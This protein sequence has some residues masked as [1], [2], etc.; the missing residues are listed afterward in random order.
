MSA[1]GGVSLT[2]DRLVLR[3]FAVTDEEAVHS[4]ASDP[5]VTQYTD[6]GPNSIDNTRAFLAEAT[7]QATDPERADFSL[8]VVLATSGELIGS[9]A[10]AV[11]SV[12]HKRG[13][14]GFVFHRDFWS[15][16]YATEAG[17]LLVHFGF[18]RLQLRRISATCHPNNSASARVLQ[19]VGLR[20]EGH[21]RSHLFV[22]G[23]W[24]SVGNRHFILLD[25][26]VIPADL[27][28]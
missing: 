4:F 7:G 17:K 2:S 15:Q 1:T 18:Q 9:A 23:S 19:K 11:T 22:R 25:N 13:E 6:W 10:I 8:A 12:Q 20:Y 16:G 5:V 14:F 3:E 26:S 24:R 21:I 28:P 27:T